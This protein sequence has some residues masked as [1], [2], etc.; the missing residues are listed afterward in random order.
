MARDPERRERIQQALREAN[1]DALVCS[2]PVNVLLL[3]GYWPVVG[4]SIALATRAGQLTI[5]AP[6]DEQ[7]LAEDAGAD[8]VRTFRP[9][10]LDRLTSA[11]DAVREPLTEAARSLG[12]E[13]TRVG[14]ESG[15]TYEPS[16]YAAMHL[17]GR[18]LAELLAQVLPD[19]TL[20]PA[21]ELLTRLRTVKTSRE[22][23]R[24]RG[25]CRIAGIA[26]HEGSRRLQ[27]GMRETGAAAL[28]RI[29]L[30]T[31]GAGVQGIARADGFT[32]CMSGPNSAKAH[33][34]YARSRA[35]AMTTGDLVLV[36]C[37]S[38]ADGYWTD[39][40][41][42][43]CLGGPNEHQQRWYQAV[44]AARRAALDVIR[45]G[46][47]ASAVDQAAREVLRVHGFGKEFKH[48]T[49]HG[50]GFA[51][52]NHNA[53]PRLHPRSEERLEVGMVFNLEPA[54]YFEGRGGLRHCDVVALTA[55]GAEV[56]TPFHGSPEELFLHSQG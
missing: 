9:G 1:L 22:I 29:P 6:E 46:E 49:G 38:Y 35:R 34:A 31:E 27:A 18:G 51:A 30:S 24:I 39:I 15:P 16:S 5:L 17:Y 47:Q 21:G 36:H 7:E 43:Y 23:D 28:F 8:E 19:T 3:T 4:T 20:T 41:R 55:T 52:I 45:P 48:S 26:F 53:R 2:L 40:T 42:T 11:M 10:S 56:L 32:F 50:V 37:N 14:Y 12:I 33:G 13:R 44:F 54:V 25:A